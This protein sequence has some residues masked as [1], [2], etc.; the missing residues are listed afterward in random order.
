MVNKTCNPGNRCCN[1]GGQGFSG[2][3]SNQ[4]QI[5]RGGGK[6][7]EVN[8]L[9]KQKELD[10]LCECVERAFCG[11]AGVF[12][13][14]YQCVHRNKQIKKRSNHFFYWG[15]VVLQRCIGFCSTTKWISF[16]NTYI[17]SC[18]S[19]PSPLIPPISVITEHRAELLALYSRFP[20]SI[21]HMVVYTCQ[22]QSPNSPH[23]PSPHRV[24]T[25]VLCICVS[26]PALQIGSSVPFSQIPHMCINIYSVFKKRQLLTPQKPKISTK[27]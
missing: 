10:R 14:I 27:K 20:L 21:S 5:E 16:E 23:L 17:P 3:K 9:E 22:S 1:R 13:E 15:T 8:S 26:I 7:R 24:H 4:F 25:S 19:L 11:P 12:E 2:L 6:L 18:P